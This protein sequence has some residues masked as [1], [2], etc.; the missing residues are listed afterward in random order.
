MLDLTRRQVADRL[1]GRGDHERARDAQGIAEVVVDVPPVN[2]LTVA[3]LVRARRRRHRRAASD[4]GDPRGRAARRG[5]GLQRRRRHQ[6]DAE[7]RGLRRPDRRQQGL[8]RRV[9]RGVRL[10]GAG[11]R[12]GAR[13]LPR[14]RH[15]PGRQRRRRSW[16]ATTPTSAC[17]RSTA[18]RSARPRTWPGWCRSTRCGRWSTPRATATAAELHAF[19]SVLEVVPRDELRDAAFEVAG[20]IAAK[21]PD[22]HPRGQGEPQRHR[23]VGR[24]ALLPLRAGLHVR[25]QPVGRVATSCATRSSTSATPT[26]PDSDGTRHATMTDKRMTEDDV[27]AELR[28]GMTIGIGG[29]GSRRKPMSL[30][31]AH[32]CARRCRTSPSSATAAPT[33]GCCARPARCARSSTRSCSLDSIALEPHFRTAR[34]DRRGRRRS[35]ST[36]ACSCSGCRPRRWR[37]PFLPTRVGLG[38]DVVDAPSPRSRTVALALRRRR[39]AGGH[40]GAPPRRRARPHAPRRRAR[41]RPV[42]RTSTRTSTTC[43]AWPR[44]ARFMSVEQ[45]VD[46]DELAAEG[47]V[48]TLRINRLMTDGVVEAPNGAHFT[49]C[50]PDYG[51]DEAFQKEYAATARS[52]T[53]RGTRSRAK[54]LD[55]GDRGRVPEGG[56][57]CERTSGRADPRP[58]SCVGRGRRLLP[59]RRRD[60]RQPDRHASR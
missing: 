58:R 34:A 14:R 12:R 49:E 25:A 24:E 33:S 28:D 3:G 47:P 17:P 41:Q 44:R 50:V 57:G 13:L 36:R 42:P 31:R 48:Q 40:A 60:P 54:Y 1:P 21:S 38:S 32:R 53:R 19:G 59:R 45:I 16:P 30:V 8:L 27:V 11:D 20:Q 51:R 26:R 22:G 9:R 2:A 35:S 5:Q 52:R 29:W 55:C 37:V 7:H 15:R 46:T 39:G 18:A 43:S 56:A 10:P 4:R 23:P 6:G